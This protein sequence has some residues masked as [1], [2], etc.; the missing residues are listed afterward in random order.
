MAGKEPRSGRAVAADVLN[1][2]DPKRDYAG[3]ALNEFLQQTTE[4]QRTT[5]L[6]LGSIRNQRAIDAVITELAGCPAARISGTVLNIIRVAVYELAYCPD[7]QQYAIVNEAVE[8]AK[9]QVAKKQAG[10]VNAVLR[11]ISSHINNREID[12]SVAQLCRTL[13]QRPSA[14]CE[15]DVDLLPAP[16]KFPAEYLS[17]AFSLPKWLVSRWF[18]EFGWQ[19][20]L[21]ICFGSNR[22]SGIYIWPNTLKTTTGDLAEKFRRQDINFEV[23]ADGAAIKVKSPRTIT[24]LPGFAEGLFH[25]Q[26]I[27]AAA[28]V[29]LLN[30]QPGW[31]IAD[32]CAGPGTKT[33]QIAEITADKT[34]ILATDIDA[35]R[36]EKVKENLDRLGIG[37]VK[38]VD[39]DKLGEII[40]QTGQFDC[41]LVDVPCSNTGVLAKRPEVRYRI[42][43]GVIKKLAAI[44]YH[45][46]EKACGMIK[47]GGK[48]C[49]S[50]C[51]IQRE[52]NSGLIRRFL[53]DNK[54]FMLQAEQLCLPVAAESDCDGGYAAIIVRAG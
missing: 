8:N 5:D 25:V 27:T 20:S 2:V 7:S 24:E 17:S 39:Y 28:A 15:F 21:Q 47:S 42:N 22:R 18:E 52:E 54:G 29:R 45:L 1:K 10:F 6:V 3:A 4:K 19:R 40:A 38:I 26:D 49:Y 48:I 43:Q 23:L 33:S 13:P 34:E 53:A 50:T 9:G 11:R 36:L 31:K 46:I 37:S 35:G 32:I 44:Q 41:V 16:E 14:G 51:S 12:L 30:P